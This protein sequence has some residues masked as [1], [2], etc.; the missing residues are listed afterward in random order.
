MNAKAEARKEKQATKI[1]Q[2]KKMVDTKIKIQKKVI[3]KL[4]MTI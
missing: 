2:E 1:K 3:I 4:L